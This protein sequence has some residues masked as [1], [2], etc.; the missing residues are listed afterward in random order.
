LKDESNHV[1]EIKE[2]STA[3]QGQICSGLVSE[4]LTMELHHAVHRDAYMS[5]KRSERDL[6]DKLKE[7][8]QELD[9]VKLSYENEIMALKVRYIFIVDIRDSHNYSR[10]LNAA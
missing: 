3:V 9:K 6:Q 8:K 10:G 7:L 1:L 4:W 2:L 5:A